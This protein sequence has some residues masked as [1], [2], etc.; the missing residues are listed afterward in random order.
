M[1][2]LK[3]THIH[4]EQNLLYLTIEVNGKENLYE[5]PQYLN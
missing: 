3:Q 4:T 5:K 2:S 1:H